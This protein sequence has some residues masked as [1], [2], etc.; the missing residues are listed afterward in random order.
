VWGCDT[1]VLAARIATLR[2]HW[3]GR[4]LNVIMGGRMRLELQRR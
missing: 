2:V 4:A 1:F 3:G